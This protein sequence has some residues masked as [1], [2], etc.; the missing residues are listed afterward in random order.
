MPLSY[1]SVS[2]YPEKMSRRQNS[3]WQPMLIGVVLVGIVGCSATSDPAPPAA[4]DGTT[5]IPIPDTTPPECVGDGCPGGLCAED[6]D[7]QQGSCVW[8]LGERLCATP[9]SVDC[10][11]GT[12]CDDT[13]NQCESLAP[14]LCRPCTDDADCREENG[15]G[16]DCVPYANEGSFCGSDCAVSE[17]CAAG[18]FCDAGQCKNGSG[19]CSCTQASIALGD[20]TPCSTT[21]EQG[22]CLGQRS[23]GAQGLTACDAWEPTVDACDGVDN[24]CDGQTDTVACDDANPCTDDSCAGANGCVFAATASQPCDD[25]D[26]CTAGDSCFLG[27]CTSE[28]VECDDGDPCTADTCV[29]SAGCLF[30]GNE[31]CTCVVDEDCSAP[32]DRCLGDVKCIL[33]AD[34][35]YFHCEQD[36]S[37][38][39]ECE[40]TP[41]P[42]APCLVSECEPTTGDCIESAANDSEPCELESKCI[43]SSICKEGV[44]TVNTMVTCEDNNPCTDNSCK[45]GL[46]CVF[47]NND[48]PCSVPDQCMENGLCVNGQCEGDTGCEDNNVCTTDACVAGAGCVHLPSQGSCSLDDPCVATGICVASQ[49]QPDTIVN[50]NDGEECTQ[51]S[52]VP[53]AGCIFVPKTADCCQFGETPAA[54]CYPPLTADAGP[55]VTILPGEST[56]LTAVASGGDGQ[57]VFTW[58]TADGLVLTGPLISVT[59]PAPQTYTLTVTDGVGNTATDK[60]T[61]LVA[62]VPLTMCEWPIVY[63]DPEGHNQAQAVWTF[64]SLC[65]TATQTVNAQP[66]I[67][68]SPID[69]ESGTLTGAF[70]VDTSDDDDL[71]GFVFG[72][73]GSTDFYVFDWKQKSQT[74]CGASS[75][76]GVML[77]KM[78]TQGDP[79]S[80]E[81]FYASGGTANTTILAAAMPPGWKENQLVPYQWTLHID[82]GEATITI[83]QGGNTIHQVV[84]TLP[85]FEGGWFGFYNNSQNWVVYELFQFVL[86]SP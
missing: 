15:L 66:S 60:V 28:P 71:I 49:C 78:K 2:R 58:K 42:N 37:T 73:K 76:E 74:F 5:E 22:T 19:L 1:R 45:E 13:E 14:M 57:Y 50:C 32:E 27:A 23:C 62:G 21:N 16:G 82:K 17:D 83:D 52:C 39:V 53:N 77:K 48:N 24:N 72:Y 67:L 65:T 4:P 68:L 86:P 31:L 85:N 26:D 81:D 61:V 8:H 30:V 54:N 56:E 75:F 43:E 64:D 51:D 18:F 79:L 38:A 10:P 69:F 46:G 36:L 59:P 47:E 41:G 84:A 44:C 9:C 40:V 29:A 11:K 34:K 7:C 70:H 35:P 25:G 20:A 63:F 12:Q 6:S 3:R 33:T 80:C 55:D